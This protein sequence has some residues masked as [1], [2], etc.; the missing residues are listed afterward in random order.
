MSRCQTIQSAVEAF[1]ACLI[2]LLRFQAI[3]FGAKV[4]DVLLFRLLHCQSLRYGTTVFC[5]FLI[6][7]PR[8]TID[9]KVPGLVA[10]V[11][12]VFLN[13]P[14]HC[15]TDINVCG[16][17]TKVFNVF[18]FNFL[19]RASNSVVPGVLQSMTDKVIATEQT[20]PGKLTMWR[21][22]EQ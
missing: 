21:L 7:L 22:H 6:S 20:K 8:Y 18:L 2:S 3:E 1:G 13:S 5:V 19:Q 12:G 16:L 10:M 15:A 9:T 14:P 17:V 4:L 11:F